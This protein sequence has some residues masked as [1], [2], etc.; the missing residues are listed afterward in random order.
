MASAM[1]ICCASWKDFPVKSISSESPPSA[2][3]G[4]TEDFRS[5]GGSDAFGATDKRGL[6]LPAR[7]VVSSLTWV[8]FAVDGDACFGGSEGRFPLV[9]VILVEGTGVA[10]A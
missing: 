8:S 1:I 10:W 2:A 5:E 9:R 4:A 3:L 7:L 6:A